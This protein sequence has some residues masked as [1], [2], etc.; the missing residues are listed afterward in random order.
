[1]LGWH[2]ERAYRFLTELGPVDAHGRQ[3]AAAAAAQLAAAGHLATGRGD[4]PAAANLLERAI[5]LLPPGDRT[6]LQLLTDLGEVLVL[7]VETERA[8]RVLDEVMA[9]AER[10]GDRGLAAHA[11]L[12]KLELRLDSPDRGPD[13]YR[14]DVQQV[15]SLLEGLGDEQGQSRAWRLLGL[16]SYLRCHDR[17]GRGRVPAGGRARPRRRRRAGRGRQ[18]VRPGPGGVLGADPGRRGDPPLPGDPRPGRGQLPG[19]DVGPPHPGRA[20]RHGR[21]VRPGPR[22]RRPGRPDRGQARPEPLRRP[23]QPVPRP[24]GAA[25]R[26]P[27]GGRALAA[28]GRRHPGADGGAG[29]ALG[30]HRQPGQGAGRPGPATTRPW[31]RPPSAASWPSATTSTPRSSGAAPWP[32]CWPGGAGWRRPSGWPP[33]RSSW[34]PT[35]TCWPCRPA[36]CSTW[37][38]CCGWPAGAP[39]PAPLARQALALAERKGHVV[40]AA[41]ARELLTTAQPGGAAV[42]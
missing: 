32:R 34:P 31:S 21:R 38:G 14:A 22:A 37:P 25:G 33:R 42:Q 26:R 29:A 2:L 3:V 20:P 7:N 27:G 39:R 12:G 8:Q 4:L 40:A 5:A 1:M 17:P 9:A 6:R 28:L 10:T 19:G 18:P 24:G 16:D 13:R 11:T 35:A 23:V 30:A 36:P 15:L 41:Q